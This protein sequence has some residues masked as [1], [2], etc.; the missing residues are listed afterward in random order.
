M[1]IPSQH[2][3]IPMARNKS[4]LFDRK[5]CFKKTTGA[6]MT[7]I[8]KMKIFDFQVSTLPTKGRTH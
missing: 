3:P 6:F 2:L 5:T 1:R 7:E 8:M 4:Y